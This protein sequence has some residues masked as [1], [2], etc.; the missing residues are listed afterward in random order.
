MLAEGALA[1]PL[2]RVKCA[3]EDKGLQSLLE[4]NPH[5]LPSEQI[6]PEN[7]PQ[8]L[9]IKREMPVIDPSSGAERWSIDFLFIDNMAVPTLVECKRC[10][11]TRARREVVAQMLEYAANGHHY[12]SAEDLQAYAQ[13]SAGGLENLDAWVS[14]A[15]SAGSGT[16]SFF[17]AA[18]ANLRKA[19]M[20]LVFFLE[21]SPP[22]LRSLV[23]FL[24]GQ[25][26]DTEVLLVEARLYDSPNG[27]V[28]VPW[29]F[30]YTEEARIAKRESR[31]QVAREGTPRGEEAYI[32]AVEQGPLEET[33]KAGIRQMLNAWPGRSLDVPH[34]SFGANAIFIVPSALRKRGLFHMARNGDLSLY[35]GYWQPEAY[36]DIGTFQIQLRDAF[37]SEM[38]KLFGIQFSDKQLRGFPTIKAATWVSKASELLSVVRNIAA[39]INGV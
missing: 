26:K 19:A 31:A 7:P 18:T 35:F 15:Y 11:D 32:A 6:S 30:G 29:L 38:Q 37:A 25:M 4:M 3:D 16:S 36:A 14:R 23:E 2:Q 5:L 22:E 8:W 27:R 17:E 9:L 28:V 20:R 24:N 10:N 39:T 34:W 1:K 21:E 12:W 13:E 33:V